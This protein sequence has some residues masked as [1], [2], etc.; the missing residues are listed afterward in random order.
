MAAQLPQPSH[1]PLLLVA[2]SLST[3]DVPRPNLDRFH[4][5]LIA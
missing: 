3:F 4:N 5:R 2:A 1:F